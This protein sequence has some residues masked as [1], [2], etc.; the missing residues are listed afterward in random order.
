MKGS[1][2]PHIR[3]DGPSGVGKTELAKALAKEV[4]TTLRDFYCSATTKIWQLARHFAELKKGDVVF[5]DE[6]HALSDSAQ[7][8]LYPAIDSH[9]VPQVD[10]ERHRVIDNEWLNIPDFT[11]IVATDQPGALKNAL[12][13]RLPLSFTLTLYPLRELREI[14]RNRAAQ[15]GILMSDQA[16]S[17]VAEAS[18][19][20]PRSVRHLLVSIYTCIPDITATISKTDVNRHLLSRG[21]DRD[22][23]TVTDRRYLNILAT[24]GEFVSLETL[25]LRLGSDDVTVRRE[26]ET[27]LI[28]RGLVAIGGRGRS[29]TH[30]GKLYVAE[31]KIVNASEDK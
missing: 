29:L 12:R 27:Y 19:G 22:N 14:V 24:S 6:G 15:I 5:L 3:L 26:V 7:E 25:V 10:M 31:H 23:L 13:Q 20:L 21:I 28:E 18:R 1:T 4:G 2:L 8:I 17:R 30:R 11:L 9:R 16:V